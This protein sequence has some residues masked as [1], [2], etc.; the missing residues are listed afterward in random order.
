MRKSL[1]AWF[2][3]FQGPVGY[4]I[5][6]LCITAADDVAL[7][8]PR[9]DQRRAH[10]RRG[11]RRLGARNHRPAQDQGQWKVVHE[12]SSVP[13]YMDGSERAAVDLKP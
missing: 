4:E 1:E 6:D 2:P 7:P 8:Q 12:H 11:N 9:S 13:F 3:T 5:H 10:E